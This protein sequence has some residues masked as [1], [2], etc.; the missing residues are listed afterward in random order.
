MALAMIWKRQRGL[1]KKIVLPALCFRRGCAYIR[2][3][4][5]SFDL[6]HEE[7]TVHIV[8][9]RWR[10]FEWVYNGNRPE[11]VMLWRRLAFIAGVIVDN[12]GGKGKRYEGEC[13]STSLPKLRNIR[14]QCYVTEAPAMLPQKW[15]WNDKAVIGNRMLRSRSDILPAFRSSQKQ[16]QKHY[17]PTNWKFTKMSSS[18]GQK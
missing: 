7:N 1:S 3:S 12:D 8:Y 11:T 9:L 6:P 2:S 13:V 10:S 18:L 4:Y 16:I 17:Y 14:Q 5:D 15:L